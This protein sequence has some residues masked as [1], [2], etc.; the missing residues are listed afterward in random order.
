[1]RPLPL[2]LFFMSALVVTDEIT[3]WGMRAADPVPPIPAIHQ[4]DEE[5]RVHH[6]EDC[7]IVAAKPRH[8]V[9]AVATADGEYRCVQIRVRHG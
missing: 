5:W 6:R 7:A 9:A 1:M 3:V 8:R 4:S 2:M